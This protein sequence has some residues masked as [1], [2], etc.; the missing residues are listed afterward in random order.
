ME[1]SNALL[2]QAADLVKAGKKQEAVKLLRNLLQSE[3]GNAR[4]WGILSMA[5]EDVEDR[6]EALQGVADYGDARMSTWAH[7]QL[8]MLPPPIS[9]QPSEP[10]FPSDAMPTSLADFEIPDA[11]PPAQPNAAPAAPASAGNRSRRLIQFGVAILVIACLLLALVFLL[12]II[13]NT[14]TAK[15]KLTA[16]PTA[17]ATE[18]QR[19]TRAPR[20]TATI[21][22]TPTP[23]PTRTPRPT[24]TASQTETQTPTPGPSPIPSR[25]PIPTRTPIPSKT[26][27]PSA[28]PTP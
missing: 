23:A 20:A 2:I 7:Q 21:T 11:P 27:K 10:L 18:T 3:P 28:T 17:T 14:L 8:A 24:P 15:P 4:A 26:P 19:P 1:Q 6:R 22:D 13:Q 5:V 12:P 16:T 25:T 9:F